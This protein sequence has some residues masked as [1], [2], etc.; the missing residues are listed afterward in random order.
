[1]PGKASAMSSQEQ[2]ASSSDG[3]P[4][5]KPDGPPQCPECRRRMTVKRVLPVLFASNL[6]DVVY[7]CNRCG[8]ETK[9][10][11]KRG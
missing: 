8:T 11:V 10:T 7:G 9:R 6:D 5:R 1:M 2:F 3:A 4:P